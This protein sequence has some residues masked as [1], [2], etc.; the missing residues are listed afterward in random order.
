MT[1]N[2]FTELQSDYSY[3][4][5]GLAHLRRSIFPVL[6]HLISCQET[7]SIVAPGCKINLYTINEREAAV[8]S[9]TRRE[10]D[11]QVI[12]CCG[13]EVATCVT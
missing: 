3:M 10:Y 2:V 4:P 11:A 5:S 7:G 6:G 9:S 1:E 8:T 13:D 12:S